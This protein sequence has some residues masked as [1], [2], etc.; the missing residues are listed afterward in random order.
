M[1]AMEVFVNNEQ[2]SVSNPQYKKHVE[3]SQRNRSVDLDIWS[4]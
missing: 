2:G 1:R 4:R 3:G